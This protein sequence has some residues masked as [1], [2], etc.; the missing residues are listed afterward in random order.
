MVKAEDTMNAEILDLLAKVQA[1]RAE[2]YAAPLNPS[3]PLEQQ[4]A[5]QREYDAA[6]HRLFNRM[7]ELTAALEQHLE[8]QQ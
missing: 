4:E 7:L 5:Q 6:Q 1:A 3:V 2:W 8:H